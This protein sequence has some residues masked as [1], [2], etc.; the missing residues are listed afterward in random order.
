MILQTFRSSSAAITN[1]Q[2]LIVRRKTSKH[3][4]LDP[5]QML[6]QKKMFH[7]HLNFILFFCKITEVIKNVFDS[8][9]I[10]YSSEL[11]CSRKQIQLQIL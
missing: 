1:P 4:P 5:A 7:L 6:Q 10:S 2:A 3:D 11:H 8:K 9:C